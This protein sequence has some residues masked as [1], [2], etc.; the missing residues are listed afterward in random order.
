MMKRTQCLSLK[1]KQESDR[2]RWGIYRSGKV[3]LSAAEIE[4]VIKVFPNC[5]L[6]LAS[7]KIASEIGQTSP[8]YDE[9]NEKLEK[10]NAG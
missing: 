3:R 2:Y 9:A 7:G 5:A 8:S 1:S 6:W 4:A 10:P